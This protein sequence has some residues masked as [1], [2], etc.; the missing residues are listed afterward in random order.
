[1]LIYF[2]ILLNNYIIV[3]K[4]VKRKK[5]YENYEDDMS[6]FSR[7]SSHQRINTPE[8]D[9]SFNQSASEEDGG[10]E[11]PNDDLQNDSGDLSDL[12]K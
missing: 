9:S 11:T 3:G 1:M 5:T 4:R 2:I 10:I 8:P 6:L 7:V 12:T